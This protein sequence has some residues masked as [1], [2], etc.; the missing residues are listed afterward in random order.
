MTRVVSSLPL[1]EGEE[2]ALLAYLGISSLMVMQLLTSWRDNM[3]PWS[4]RALVLLL[5]VMRLSPFPASMAPFL[6]GMVVPTTNSTNHQLPT[7]E[8]QMRGER[9]VDDP[10]LL[11][12][13]FC[14]FSFTSL[15]YSVFPV[16]DAVFVTV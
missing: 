9:T 10:R 6:P 4:Y 5:N 14:V 2:S 7:L 13:P 15:A 3:W 1:Y 8:D 11:G 16:H 12:F